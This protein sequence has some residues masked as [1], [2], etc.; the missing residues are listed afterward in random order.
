LDD[1][2]TNRKEI[3]ATRQWPF[4]THRKIVAQSVWLI[5]KNNVYF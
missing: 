4:M 5:P 3:L 2:I 1:R